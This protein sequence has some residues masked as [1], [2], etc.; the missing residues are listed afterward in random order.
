MI[1]GGKSGRT[2][3]NLPGAESAADD[4]LRGLAPE[5]RAALAEAS[6]RIS[7]GE[8]GAAEQL[9]RGILAT[10]P[11]HTETLRLLAIAYQRGGRT[12]EAI[13]VVRYAQRS[14]PTDALLMNTLGSLLQSA[15]DIAGGGTAFRRACELDPNLAA[16]WMNLGTNLQIQSDMRQ[17]ESAFARGRDPADLDRCTHCTRAGTERARPYRREHRSVPRCDRD[18]SA[19]RARVGGARRDQDGRA[20]RQRH[21]PP[22]TARRRCLA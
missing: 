12:A 19:R 18:E 1:A 4:R 7:R 6:Q 10:S 11:D 15:G 16:A 13:G 3:A 8:V 9:L 2:F 5:A 14:N 20:H 17:A 22:R 21:R